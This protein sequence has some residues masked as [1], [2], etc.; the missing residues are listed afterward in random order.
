MLIEVMVLSSRQFFLLLVIIPRLRPGL[1]SLRSVLSSRQ[2]SFCARSPSAL[3]PCSKSITD[4]SD[5]TD[6]FFHGFF[7]LDYFFLSDLYAPVGRWDFHGLSLAWYCVPD[8]L[9]V[10]LFSCIEGRFGWKPI[11]SAARVTRDA[12]SGLLIMK[13]ELSGRQYLSP[14]EASVESDKSVFEKSSQWW[15]E[16]GLSGLTRMK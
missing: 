3:S 15:H 11:P 8:W 1:L 13:G 12:V 5:A 16:H 9:V 7:Y 14:S 6:L 10:L 2:L 4:N